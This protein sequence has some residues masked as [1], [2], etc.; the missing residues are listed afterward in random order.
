MV[1]A[2][3]QTLS[4]PRPTLRRLAP[5]TH[6]GIKLSIQV[7]AA[8]SGGREKPL[9]IIRFSD[10]GI[11]A[12]PAALQSAMD[13]ANVARFDKTKGKYTAPGKGRTRGVLQTWV[14]WFCWDP[15]RVGGDALASWSFCGRRVA[16]CASLRGGVSCLHA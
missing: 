11:L 1:G 12:M 9:K 14:R 10:E 4:E 8:I 7:A 5:S 16:E 6:A 2:H 15:R 13:Y 3:T